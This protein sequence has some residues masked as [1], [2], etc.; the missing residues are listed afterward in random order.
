ME[1]LVCVKRVPGD[2][3]PD[4]PDARTP[5]DRHAVPR[6]HDQPARGMR[7]RGGRPDRRGAGRIVGRAH[8][9]AGRR[10]GAAPRRHGDRDRPGDPA[11]DRRPRVRPGRDRGAR[12]PTSIRAPGGRARPVRPDP[13]RQRGRGHAAT[14]RSAIRVAVALDRPIV[15]GIKS[16]AVARR[17]GR[18]ARREAPTA[19][20]R[21][22]RSRCPRSSRS[23]RAST[24]RATR[25]SRAG[26][27]RSARRSSGSNQPGPRAARPKLG[28][29]LPEERG[30]AQVEI[31]GTGPD[32]APAVVDLLVRIGVLALVSGGPRLRRARRRRG[33]TGCRARRWPWPVRWRRRSAGTSRRS[34]L[35]TGA[36]TPRRGLGGVGV[37]T[38][39]RRRR[40]RGWTPTPRPPGRRRAPS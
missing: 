40:R 12:S 33:R 17:R 8:A 16:L 32:A 29:R 19:A 1:I 22:T 18:A 11:R 14:S 30:H 35:G 25:R 6:L 28:L 7:R 2:R 20:G 15:T 37:A 3:R 34:L 36:A 39:A 23:R 5:G 10:R 31:L 24:C 9:R 38:V 27:G 26:C 21:P 4:R 13:V